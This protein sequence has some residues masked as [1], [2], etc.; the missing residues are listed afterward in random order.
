[1]TT[2]AM[3]ELEKL[4]EKIKTRIAKNANATNEYIQ[5]KNETEKDILM[6]LEYILNLNR[7]YRRN[8]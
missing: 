8:K 6:E 4:V 2:I 1:M 3:M 7:I 5:I